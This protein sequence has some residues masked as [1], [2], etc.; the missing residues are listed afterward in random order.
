MTLDTIRKEYINWIKENT[1]FSKM[2]NSAIEISSPFMD[3]LNDN[4]TLYVEPNNNNFKITD[5][6]YTIWNLESLGS[7]IKKG[8]KRYNMLQS[9]INRYNI[10]FDADSKELYFHSQKN[11]LGSSIHYLLQT[12]LTISDSL[13]INKNTIQGL[14]EEEVAKYFNDYRDIF[15]PFPDIDI[16]G[17]SKLMHRFDYLMTVQ[18][19]RKKLVRLINNLNQTQLERVLLSWQDTSNQR[20]ELYNENLGMV[21]LINDDKK[22]ISNDFTEAFKAYDIEPVGFSDKN[23]VRESLAHTS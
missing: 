13:K 1:K 4:I 19:K 3:S 10:S 14:F 21:A 2:L 9:I 20:K 5:E 18:N 23:A 8:S 6:G 22:P 12:T 17:K 16:Q 11:E 15:D 7:S